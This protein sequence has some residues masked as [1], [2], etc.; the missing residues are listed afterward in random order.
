MVEL[1]IDTGKHHDREVP[2]SWHLHAKRSEDLINEPDE[3]D[4][5]KV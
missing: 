3:G 2:R 4:E 1:N 5:A